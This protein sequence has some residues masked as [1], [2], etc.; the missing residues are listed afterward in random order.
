MSQAIPKLLTLF[1]ATMMT[2]GAVAAENNAGE[3]L[4]LIAITADRICTKAATGGSTRRMGASISVK[5][6]L[7]NLLRKLAKIGAGIDGSYQSEV[8]EGVL[9][10]QVL[11][12]ARASDQ[13]KIQVLE[14]L[15]DRLLPGAGARPLQ[16]SQTTYGAKSPAIGTMNG[17]TVNIHD[18]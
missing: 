11:D 9:A 10:D 18:P 8:H 17:G 3:T 1:A 15:S 5:A 2:T 12:A 4:R 16:G 13:C 14:L 6:E 7:D